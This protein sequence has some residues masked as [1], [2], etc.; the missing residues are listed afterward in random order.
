M[1][2]QGPKVTFGVT[3]PDVGLKLDAL[4]ELAKLDSSFPVKLSGDECRRL[5]KELLGLQIRRDV[6]EEDAREH[7]HRCAVAEQS[8][9]DLEK[10]LE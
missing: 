4:K 10:E 1:A 6:I 7:E 8:F 5:A 2:S 3:A 9:A